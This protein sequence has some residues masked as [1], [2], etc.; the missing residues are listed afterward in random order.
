MALAVPSNAR[1]DN[2]GLRD[3]RDCGECLVVP[4]FVCLSGG[5]IIVSAMETRSTIPSTEGRKIVASWHWF[6]EESV[7]DIGQRNGG[8]EKKL[9]G[10][11]MKRRKG[12]SVQWV[13]EK[14]NY[15]YKQIKGV[16]SSRKRI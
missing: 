10:E 11:D 8:A 13:E 3:I 1:G 15:V 5:A 6:P 9:N 4:G 12:S 7:G 14:G 2:A 16:A